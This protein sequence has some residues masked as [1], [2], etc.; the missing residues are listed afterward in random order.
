M[1]GNIGNTKTSGKSI[2]FDLDG[3]RESMIRLAEKHRATGAQN[4]VGSVASKG[5]TT[6]FTKEP[7]SNGTNKTTVN[8][9]R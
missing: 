8:L 9:K 3:L 4:G 6:D 2:D 5:N 7:K 1:A